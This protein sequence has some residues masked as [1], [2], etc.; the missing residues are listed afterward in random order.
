[1]RD[2]QAAVPLTAQC[3]KVGFMYHTVYIKIAC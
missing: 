2:S 3:L 1:M